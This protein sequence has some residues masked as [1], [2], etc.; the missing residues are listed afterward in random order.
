M[1]IDS[2]SA[3]EHRLTVMDETRDR[4]GRFRVNDFFCYD[5]TWKAVLVRLAGD[6]E[7]VL[8]DLRG[9]TSSNAGCIFEIGALMNSVPLERVVFVIDH[10]TDEPLLERILRDAWKQL[11]GN[12]PNRAYKQALLRLVKIGDHVADELRPMLMYLSMASRP[13]SPASPLG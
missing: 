2:T 12:S 9:F 4:D 1:F 11:A 13:R 10:T 8:M 6:C 5:T 3:L 7:V